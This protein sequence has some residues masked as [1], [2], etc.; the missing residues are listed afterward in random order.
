[1]AYV[2]TH[3]MTAIRF[4]F[5]RRCGQGSVLYGMHELAADSCVEDDLKRAK[6]FCLQSFLF[7][8]QSVSNTDTAPTGP[9]P[10]KCPRR[11]ASS[12]VCGSESVG[13]SIADTCAPN[14]APRPSERESQRQPAIG[15]RP[16]GDRVRCQYY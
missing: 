9:G 8:T 1:V 12:T 14:V 7:K 10:A 15:L 11:D 2:E 6:V 16:V 3:V 5:W 13:T 4:I